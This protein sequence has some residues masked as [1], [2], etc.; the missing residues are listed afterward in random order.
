MLGV[1]VIGASPPASWAHRSHVP[2]LSVVPGLRLA[3]VSTSGPKSAARAAASYGVPALHDADELARRADVDIVVVAVNVPAHRRLIGAALAVGKPVYCEWPLGVDLAEATAIAAETRSVGV[4]AAIGLQARSSPTLRMVADL[5]AEGGIGQVESVAATAFSA[6]GATPVTPSKRYL[7]DRSA[8]ANTLTIEGGHLLD[9]LC[10]LLGE[11]IAISGRAVTRRPVV[12]DDRDEPLAAT[13]P[14][15][16]LATA[17]FAGGVPASVHVAQGTTALFRTEICVTGSRGALV[18]RTTAPGGVQM[19]P[20]EVLM[21]RS[22][23]ADLTPLTVPGHYRTVPDPA[24]PTAV[25][26]AEALRRFAETAS[27]D[28]S[29]EAG[30]D[31]AVRRQAMLEQLA[32]I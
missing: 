9:A 28:R 20:I 6:R 22:A 27:I 7:F 19:A 25:N 15:T 12:V 29:P 11:P 26:V 23:T 4:P 18:L 17:E 24:V 30:F 1:G 3:A 21:A 8:G 32:R 16:V 2:A 31:L 10:F 13:S 5:L 14:D